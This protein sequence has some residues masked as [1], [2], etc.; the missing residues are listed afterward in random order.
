MRSEADRLIRSIREFNRFYTGIIGLLDRPVPGGDISP[1]DA[2]V[3]LEIGGREG[4]PQGECTA[5]NLSGELRMDPGYLS[6]ILGRLEGGGMV[7]RRRSGRDGRCTLLGLT[8][9]GREVL[10]SLN[11]A[12][13]RRVERM[14]GHLSAGEQALLSGSM[15]AIR[16]L[17]DPGGERSLRREDVTVRWDLRPGDVGSVIH[18]HGAVYAEEFGY[19]LEFEGYVADTFREFAR[20]YRPGKD[21]LWVVEL[22]G[23]IV[24]SLAVLGR[25]A[26]EAQLRWFLLHPSCRGL[27]LGRELLHSALRFCRERGYRRAYLLTTSDQRKASAMYARA[28][29]RKTEEK[30]TRMWGKEL[31]EERWELVL[32]DAG[33]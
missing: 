5:A 20:I 19:N 30:P 11:R 27:G 16:E 2:R 3:L 10:E 21:R 26:R 12:A 32:G 18:L 1:A 8:E 31:V 13:D 9:K 4:G 29:F 28:G 33:G 22:G 6:R 24:G 14:T 7:D 23:S 17:L 25:P 15:H